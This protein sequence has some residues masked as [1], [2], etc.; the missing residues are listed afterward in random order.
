[1]Y[2]THNEEGELER[3]LWVAPNDAYDTGY[4]SLYRLPEYISRPS[5]PRIVTLLEKGKN[6]G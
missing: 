6:N 2:A 4:R 5:I 3:R 1:L